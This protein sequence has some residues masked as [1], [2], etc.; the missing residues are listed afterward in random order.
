M[1]KFWST[2]HPESIKELHPN[3][4]LRNWD[5]LSSEEKY[6]IWR[7]IE[8]FFTRKESAFRI[9]FAIYS[10]NEKHK[11]HSYAKHFLQNSTFDNAT[12]DFEY[13]FKNESQNVFFE[14]LSCFSKSVLAER[15]D[16]AIPRELKEDDAEYKKRLTDWKYEDFDKFAERLNDVFEHF[17]INVVLT[18]QGFIP[19]QDDRITKEIYIPILQVLSKEEWGPVNRDLHDAFKEYQAKTEHGYSNCI[20]HTVSALQAFLQILVNGKIG[21]SDGISNLIKYAQEK[22]LIPTDKFSSEI[23][24]NIETILMRERGK[25]GDAHPKKEYAN[26]KNSRLVLNLV[27]V[28]LQHCIQK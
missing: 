8:K 19:K 10:L 18:R 21:G 26:E 7:Y 6:K 1:F 17:G 14:L 5:G 24:K 15:S 28:F 27:M 23:F 16:K 13:I 11:Y 25:S 20:T 9:F 22:G 12:L 3:L 2:T 4:G